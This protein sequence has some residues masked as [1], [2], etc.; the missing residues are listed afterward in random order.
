VKSTGPGSILYRICFEIYFYSH[1]FQIYYSKNPILPCCTFLLLIYFAFYR[2][3]FIQSTTNILPSTW[4]FIA[5]LPSR[6]DNPSYASGCKYLFFV[7]RYRLHSVAWFSYWIHT[8]VSQLREILTVAILH[9]PFLF[10][11]IITQFQATSCSPRNNHLFGLL[12]FLLLM[13]FQ[14]RV[15]G[16]NAL[17]HLTWVVSWALYRSGRWVALA[18][19]WSTWLTIVVVC[20]C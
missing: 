5:L 20:H 3:L 11:E 6:I 18:R 13:W 12:C 7:C 16:S 10:G 19:Q 9:H 4:Q 14:V 2:E 17:G 1:L 15:F 8:L